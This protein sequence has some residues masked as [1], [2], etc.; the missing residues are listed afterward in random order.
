MA[1]L[2]ISEYASLASDERNRI[3]LLQCV[4][5]PAITTQK[6]TIGAA[7]V[8]SLP[9]SSTTKIIRVHTDA[10][11]SVVVTNSGTPVATS[12]NKRMA[13]NQTE[14]FGVEPGARIAVITNT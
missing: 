3:S 9:F 2:Y 12:S 7:S 13:A 6:L 14:Y 11:C 8:S 1:S 10:I 4:Q 5:E